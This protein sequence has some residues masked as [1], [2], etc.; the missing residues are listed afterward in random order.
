MSNI[1]RGI[2]RDTLIGTNGPD[3][4]VGGAGAL[5]FNGFN[6]TIDTSSN[7]DRMEGR[8]GNDKYE[9]DQTR[10]ESAVD[11]GNVRVSMSTSPPSFFPDVVIEKP[12]GGIDTVI[13][14]VSYTL[15]ANVENLLLSDRFFDING[16]G[17]SL[18]NRITG[19]GDN[20]VLRGMAGN[21]TLLGGFGNDLLFGGAG[22]DVLDGG[23]GRDTASYADASRGMTLNLGLGG[24]QN[25]GAMGPDKLVNIEVVAGSKFADTITGGLQDDELR[26]EAG[27]D[28]LSGGGGDDTLVGGAGN[29]RL[30]GDAGNDTLTGGEGNDLLLGGGDFDIASFAGARSGV[31]VDLA[32]TAA[33]NTREGLDTLRSIEGVAGS[34]HADIL[35]GTADVNVLIGGAGDDLL[36]GR[37]GADVLVGGAGDDRFR[38]D[39][40][41]SAGSASSHIEDFLSGSDV[42][43]LSRGVFDAFADLPAGSRLSAGVLELG[44]EATSNDTRLLFDDSNGALYYDADGAATQFAPIQFAELDSFTL[45]RA[46]DFVVV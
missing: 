28:R 36:R 27:N 3:F 26:G 20:N 23:D 5:R 6:Y 32:L 17:N 2:G 15:P 42:L 25:T 22:R 19:N 29:D 31:R 11:G 40:A 4:L 14:L 38:F 18:A 44:S 43:E 8:S 10:S 1:V 13:A 16:T 45:L 7:G 35:A 46:S 9:V 33:Q 37:G 24:F 12:G 41:L 30:Q 34:S 39:T 21:D